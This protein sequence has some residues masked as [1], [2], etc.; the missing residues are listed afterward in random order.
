MKKQSFCKSFLIF[1]CATILFGCVNSNYDDISPT[2][3]HKEESQV[4]SDNN[5][6]DKIPKQENTTTENKRKYYTVVKVVDGDTI[7]VNINGNDETL[8][9]IGIDTPETVHPSKPVECFGIEASNKAKELLNGQKVSLEA[10]STQGKRDKYGRLLYYVFL[11]DGTHFNKLM[12]RDGYAY[13]YTY[14]IPYKY[15]N[16]FKEAEQDA[17]NNKRG[18]W[19]DGACGFENIDNATPEP[20]G[21]PTQCECSYNKYNCSDFKTHAEAQSLYE[22]CGGVNKDVHGLDRDKNGQACESLP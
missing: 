3:P 1:S 20:V 6:E 10:D 15:Q 2:N 22:C 18:L 19:A 13:E 8:R 21:Q 11:E 12:I 5:I 7:T 17:K 9:L 14:N 4:I 16:E